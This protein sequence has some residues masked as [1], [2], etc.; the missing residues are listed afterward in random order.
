MYTNKNENS[1]NSV[2]EQSSPVNKVRIRINSKN[3]LENIKEQE[4]EILPNYFSEIKNLKKKIFPLESKI[5]NI[6]K[7]F[8]IKKGNIRN[9]MALRRN[10]FIDLRTNYS[11]E[12][13]NIFFQTTELI[14]EK[15]DLQEINLKL[16]NKLKEKEN[17]ISE[18][19]KSLNEF[20]NEKKYEEEKYLEKIGN[21]ENKIEEMEKISIEQKNLE[22][23]LE[24]IK[25]EYNNYKDN[26]E[27]EL[28]EKNT[29]IENLK[30]EINKKE[31]EILDIKNNIKNLEFENSQLKNKDN[32][33]DKKDT[34]LIIIENERLKNENINLIE[35][36]KNIENNTKQNIKDKEEEINSLKEEIQNYSENLLKS[37]NEK[38]EEI[39][40]LNIEKIN[41]NKEI[42]EL[43][44]ENE[45]K[46]KEIEELNS[47]ILSLKNQIEQKTKELE[48]IILINKQLTENL[49]KI[50]LE[51][52]KDLECKDKNKDLLL[53]KPKNEISNQYFMINANKIND[54]LN[55][56]MINS[57]C[58]KEKNILSISVEKENSKNEQINFAKR[59]KTIEPRDN[60]DKIGKEEI[61]K[62]ET[63]RLKEEMAKLK[64]KYLN[65]EFENETKIAKYKNILK[66]IEQQCKKVGVKVDLNFEKV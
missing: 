63:D 37:Q 51:Y 14:K 5:T 52:Q 16:M 48:E 40:N 8:N 65:M 32:N 42:I 17:E 60:G 64:I 47:N 30:E 38:N 43:K 2:K 24:D 4:E 11:F 21:L 50:K 44:Q 35:K 34:D 36:I 29:N 31:N 33:E 12:N 46:Q 20:K 9:E 28:N 45:I 26:M 3:D 56:N 49:D 25:N 54:N 15:I 7:E 19:N 58:S 57:S 22:R 53:Q 62:S 27:R 1:N 66:N 23:N 59:S 18:L 61:I 6:K 13:K 41:N 55:I 39:S 10:T